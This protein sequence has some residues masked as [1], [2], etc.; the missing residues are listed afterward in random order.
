[1]VQC[2]KR[3]WINTAIPEG[4]HLDEGDEVEFEVEKD[5]K[6]PKAVNLKKL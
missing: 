4:T 5:E 1:M 3:V 2:T 6:G